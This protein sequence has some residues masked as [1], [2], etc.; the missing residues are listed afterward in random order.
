MNGRA[1]KV[2][3]GHVGLNCLDVERTERFYSRYFG[4][5]RDREIML[6]DK[7]LIFISSG[8][9]VFELFAANGAP[10]SHAGTGPIAP[11]FRHLA[12]QV[13]DV[14]ALLAKVA[15]EAETTLGPL[16]LSEQGLSTAIAWL[17]DP[18]G[19]I[20]EIYQ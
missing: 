15:G 16:D 7:K 14:A 1:D 17:R 13:A 6:G 9:V 10:L 4:F 19:R 11:G 12:I 3:F 18:D 5:T 20:L 8:N 2:K